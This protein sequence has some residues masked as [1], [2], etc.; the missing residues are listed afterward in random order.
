LDERA[1]HVRPAGRHPHILNDNPMFDVAALAYLNTTLELLDQMKG[2]DTQPTALYMS[3]S[4]KGQARPVLG[5]RL[6]NAGHAVHG[7]TAADE[8]HVP[9]RTAA[10]ANGGYAWLQAV[11]S[12]WRS[13]RLHRGR[14]RGRTTGQL[15]DKTPK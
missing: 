7:V 5:R 2:H 3:S 9:S 10:I 6:T 11:L 14:G 15:C 1:A 8:F 4:G 13:H 12:R